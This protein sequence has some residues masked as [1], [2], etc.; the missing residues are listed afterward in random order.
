MAQSR[1]V[2]EV[3]EQYTDEE[4]FREAV[5]GKKEAQ[6][7]VRVKLL[8][9]TG[10]AL[11]GGASGGQFEGTLPAELS[12]LV[13]MVERAPFERITPLLVEKIQSGT[14]PRDMVTAAM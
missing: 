6:R 1:S 12:G 9:L 8:G 10:G 13:D 5:K 7:V 2:A 4:L 11:S 14:D 3:V